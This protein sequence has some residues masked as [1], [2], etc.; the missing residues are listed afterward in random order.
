MSTASG[1]TTNNNNKVQ[2][3][4]SIISV[5]SLSSGTS[6]SSG[7]CNNGSSNRH[8]HNNNL[9]LGERH[10]EE[11]QQ[12]VEELG[13]KTNESQLSGKGTKLQGRRG[14]KHQHHRSTTLVSQCSMGKEKI[15][16]FLLLMFKPCNFLLFQRVE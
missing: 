14:L 3:P 10:I 16:Q 11:E 4:N 1:E 2:R 13:N 8:L 15:P 7:S 9:P 6:S 5:N 12:S